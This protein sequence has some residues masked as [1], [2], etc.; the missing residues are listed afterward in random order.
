MSIMARPLLQKALVALGVGLSAFLCARFTIPLL[1]PLLYKGAKPIIIYIFEFFE[2][3]IFA[4][5][6]LVLVERT[7]LPGWWAKERSKKTNLVVALL[8]ATL[9]AAN[10]ALHYYSRSEA[11]R[12][13]PWVGTLDLTQAFFLSLRAAIT[14][15]I[16]FRLFLIS[17]SAWVI[18]RIFH[19]RRGAIG[20]G[21]LV[22]SLLFG[23]IH[24][25]FPLPFLMGLAMAYI[26]LRVG[27]LPAMAVHFL[28]DF[29]PFSLWALIW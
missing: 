8:G 4:F 27:L 26:Y 6:G 11:L 20:V 7:K 2:Y 15:E 10:M 13:A 1:Q 18:L 3:A 28:G 9:V 29:V 25:T 12:L 5:L 23:L 17:L 21:V 16:I 19:N 22:S 14:E 24:P